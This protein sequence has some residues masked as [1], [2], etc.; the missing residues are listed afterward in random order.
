LS[1]RHKAR[2]AVLKAMYLSESRGISVDEAIDELLTADADLASNRNDPELKSR[3]PFALRIK[4]KQLTFARQLAREV[5]E[6]GETLNDNI[7]PFLKNWEM[8]RVSRIDRLILWIAL[9]EM[10]SFMDIPVSVSIN[11]AIELAK[12][13]SSEKSPAF[14]NGILDSASKA[15]SHDGN[16]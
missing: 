3:R 6:K 2:E 7:I 5:Q 1:S 10:I 8:S 14:V 9:T 11:E 12:T 13:Y 16:L 15:L 4:G